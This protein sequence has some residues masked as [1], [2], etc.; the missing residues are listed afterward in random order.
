MGDVLVGHVDVE[1]LGLVDQVGHGVRLVD[2]DGVDDL[3]DLVHGDGRLQPLRAHLGHVGPQQRAHLVGG[4][5]G[6]RRRRELVGHVVDGLVQHVD[7]A[8][9]DG[10]EPVRFPTDR[11]RRD[12]EH[13]HRRQHEDDD[14]EDH[15]ARG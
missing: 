14:D 9:R 6:L 15:G 7:G 2:H 8:G 10:V 3:L 5:P 13:G 11:D 12:A 1:P 4:E